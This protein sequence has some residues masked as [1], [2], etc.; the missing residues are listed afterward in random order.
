M[1]SHSNGI[2]KAVNM[3]LTKKLNATITFLCHSASYFRSSSDK[4][5]RPTIIIICVL[6]SQVQS[7]PITWNIKISQTLIVL[8]IFSARPSTLH[9]RQ[10]S[11]KLSTCSR[12]KKNHQA[13]HVNCW[14]WKQRVNSTWIK[15]STEELLLPR[16]EAFTLHK[17]SLKVTHFSSEVL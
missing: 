5:A 16:K 6:I 14:V 15:N 12:E 1:C 4:R 9:P 8:N 11:N 2:L 7:L 3:C 17:R 13:T 10:I